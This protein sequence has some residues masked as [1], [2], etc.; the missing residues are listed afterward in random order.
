MRKSIKLILTT[1]VAVSVFAGCTKVPVGIN[2]PDP[3]GEYIATS[4]DIK[5]PKTIF[6]FFLGSMKSQQENYYAQMG[7]DPA[8]LEE[9]WT[10]PL[11][12]GDPTP[13]ETLKTD[14]I[15][16]V[17][18]F[19]T[20]LKVAEDQKIKV[21]PEEQLAINKQIDDQVVAMN[22]EGGTVDGVTTEPVNGEEAFVKEMNVT[23]A[24]M[25]AI[26]AIVLKVQTYQKKVLEESK[27][28]KDEIKTYYDA[29][30]DKY[31]QV[32]I[33]HILIDQGKQKTLEERTAIE[34]MTPEE[35]TALM[36]KEAKE[37]EALTEEDKTK[38]SEAAKVIAED[39]LAQV[40]AGGDM[41]ELAAKYSIDGGSKDNSGE[42][43]FGKGEMVPEFDK[44]SFEAKDGDT[45]IV[46]TQ[47]G[48]HVVK[49]IKKE[50][51]QLK[52]VEAEIEKLLQ[53]QKS[54]ETITKVL[55]D[56]KLEWVVDEEML[57]SI[58]L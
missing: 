49:F 1:L 26:S 6:K 9:Y 29:N 8:T 51:K 30:I 37:A 38:L 13:Y 24:E 47:Y 32:T 43:T 10:K 45:G 58:T 50:N 20:L 34:A 44:W 31:E 16:S 15:K 28:T 36:E 33:Q 53:D 35:Q 54:E 57:K 23:P 56:N 22:V 21:L 7:M 18:D 25:K 46:K 40:K 5:I 3:N 4:G 27:P 11:K 19:Y 41:K 55:E 17:E 48:Y 52:D 42:Y 12:E 2:T 14:S 39:V